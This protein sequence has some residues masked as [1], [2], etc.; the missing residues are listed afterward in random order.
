MEDTYERLLDRFTNNLPRKVPGEDT[1]RIYIAT[2]LHG[3]A[4]EV[5]ILYDKIAALEKK[6]DSKQNKPNILGGY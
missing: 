1:M 3:V 6:I 5:N 2:I 4:A